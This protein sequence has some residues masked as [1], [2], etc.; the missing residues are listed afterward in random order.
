[1]IIPLFLLAIAATLPTPSP[2]PTPPPSDIQKIRQAVQQKVREKLEQ[3]TNANQEN[4]LKAFA[5]TISQIETNEITITVNGD[6]KILSFTPETVCIDLKRNKS[7]VGN[8][9]TGQEILAMGRTDSAGNLKTTRI[10]AI[11][12]D[13]TK[14]K[15]QIIF[16]KITDISQTSPV[17]TLIP[18]SNKNQQ[19]QVKT[20]TKTE[21]YTTAKN[22]IKSA[23]LQKSHRAII[24]TP[25]TSSS[26]LTATTIIDLD[27]QP[28][29][30]PSPSP[31][32]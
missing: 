32:P 15:Y 21:I 3:I 28:P 6:Q 10:V 20:D 2:S 9:K 7:L 4:Q 1:M 30:T 29:V 26:T 5:G 12:P 24:V 16:G 13:S 8:L 18:F 27:Y 23:D 22:K 11:E 14:A 19:F 17:F 31:K 25:L